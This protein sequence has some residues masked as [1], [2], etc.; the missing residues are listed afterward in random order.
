[1]FAPLYIYSY[2]TGALATVEAPRRNER[3]ASFTEYVVLLA[4][5]VAVVVAGVLVLQ[6][7]INGKLASITP[8][9]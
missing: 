2:V 8:L 5:I 3:G 4:G 7:L 1:M 9:P 6:G